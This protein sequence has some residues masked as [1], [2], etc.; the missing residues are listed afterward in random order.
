MITYNPKTVF[1]TP[2]AHRHAPFPLED[3]IG[4][5]EMA[6]WAESRKYAILNRRS[7]QEIYRVNFCGGCL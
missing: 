6:C 7:G 3:E 1:K 4:K 2:D 5:E